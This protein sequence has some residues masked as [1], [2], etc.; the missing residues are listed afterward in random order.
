M[1]TTRVNQEEEPTL[2]DVHNVCFLAVFKAC[3][4]TPQTSAM[5]SHG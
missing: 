4:I 1:A 5:L 3:G 2:N